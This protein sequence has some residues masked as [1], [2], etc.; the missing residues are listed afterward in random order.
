M[1]TR[2]WSLVALLVTLA[3]PGARAAGQ[4]RERRL[5]LASAEA[6]SYLVNDWNRFQENYL[7]LY[8]GDDDP[9]TA[10]DLKTEGI[11][12][13]IRMHVTPMESATHV[14]M[15]I[16]NGYQK[17]QK[18]FAAN[19]RAKTLTVVLLPSGKTVDVELTDSFGWQEISVDQPAG[20]LNAVELR[21]KA[22]YPGKKYDD[23]CLSDVQLYV[24]ATTPDNPV[25]EKQHFQKILTWKQERV[26]A[27]KLFKTELGKSLPIAAQYQHVPPPE[28]NEEKPLNLSSCPGGDAACQ[29]EHSLAAALDHDGP[30]GTHAAAQRA[31][32]ALAH[33]KFAT[34]TAG[35]VTAQD[36]RTFPQVDGLCTP[37][38]DTCSGNP[39][40]DGAE[41]PITGQL[42]YL[43]ADGV[44]LAEQTGLPSIADLVALKPAACNT[45]GGGLYA[46]ASRDATTDGSA[47]RIRTLLLGQCGLV[48]TRD[49]DA[50]AW[51]LQLLVYGDDGRLELVA[52]DS[53]AAAL[54]WRS[55]AEGPKLA[56]A[57]VSRGEGDTDLFIETP[58]VAAK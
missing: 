49:G 42:G 53:Q 11:G 4:A 8:V 39:C 23:L 57:T 51:Q 45:K 21:V 29:I 46:W 3:A 18:L 1:S 2:R 31:A 48:E 37:P 32:L 47:G 55:G 6:S 24:T 10:W 58:A 33:A 19:S 38:L 36:K 12:E 35:R 27:A 40:Y 26:A 50:P 5:H 54:D 44:A 17:T 41:L 25:Y 56:R 15:K 14:R 13:W 43:R 22:V 7:P 16:R 20:P 52:D 34:L 30:R 28:G 9:R